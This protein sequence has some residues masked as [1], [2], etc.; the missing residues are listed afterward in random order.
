M[1]I[2]FLIPNILTAIA[3]MTFPS[4]LFA[5]SC[6]TVRPA[7]AFADAT[8]VFIGRPVAV[9]TL[10]S[11]GFIFDGPQRI[12][13][14]KVFSALKGSRDIPE[15]SSNKSTASCGYP[16]ALSR[17]YLVYT[18]SNGEFLTSALCNRTNW[19]FFA[20]PDLLSALLHIEIA[21]GFIQLLSV[22]RCFRY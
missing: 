5:C 2:R 15:V 11:G 17:Y 8:N 13:R 12:Y 6:R 18:K 19:L 1:R 20:G 14:F 7:E 9:R 3:I 16:F 21:D 4:S 10:P 22:V